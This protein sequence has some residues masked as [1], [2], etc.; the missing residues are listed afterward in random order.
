MCCELEAKENVL[1]VCDVENKHALSN[2]SFINWQV[3]SNFIIKFCAAREDKNLSR[4][5]I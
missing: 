4:R 5:H 1:N 2:A 3:T